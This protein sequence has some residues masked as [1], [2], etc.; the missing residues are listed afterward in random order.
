MP[1]SRKRSSPDGM[2]IQV[3]DFRYEAARKNL[4]EAGIEAQGRIQE[5]PVRRYAYDPHLPPVLRFDSTGQEDRL[6][7]LL[8]DARQRPLTDEETK[9]LAEALRERQPW[10]E[11]TGKREADSFTV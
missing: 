6:P 5:E 4:P 8:E 1:R 11:W 3:S 7:E 10:L 2:D 9:L